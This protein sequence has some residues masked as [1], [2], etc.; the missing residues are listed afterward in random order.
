[1]TF[2]RLVPVLALACAVLFPAPQGLAQDR[3]LLVPGKQTVFQRV[4][5]RDTIDAM[6]AP[7]GAVAERLP[8]FTP[9]YVYAR[10]D[11]WT[12]VGRG[13]VGAEFYVET[14]QTVAWHQNIVAAFTLPFGRNRQLVMD[15]QEA[16]VD[17]LNHEAVRSEQQRRLDAADAGRVTPD[18]G[19][20]SVEPRQHVDIQQQFYVMPILGFVEDLHP[21]SLA[22]NLLLNVASLP[23]EGGTP[24]DSSTVF[25]AGVVFVIDTTQSM[26]PYIDRTRDIVRRVITEVEASDIGKRIHFGIIAFRDD[27]RPNPALEYRTRVILPLERRATNAPVVAA[28]DKLRAARVSSPGF[29]ED[30]F[31]G[32]RAAID[33]TDWTPN[34]A[35][36][37]GRYVIL[38]TDAGPK[39]SNSPNLLPGQE[40][41]ALT[42]R[43][44][45][46]ERGVGI[47]TFHLQTDEGEGNHTY[48]TSQY[49]PLST[50][51]SNRYLFEV[52]DG[53]PQA[54][55]QAAAA[56]LDGLLAHVRGEFAAAQDATEAER[57]VADLGLAMRLAWLG[58]TTGATAPDVISGWVSNLAVENG[59]RVAFEPRLLVNKNEL[60]TMAEIIQEFI[61][62]GE[63]IRS[64]RDAENFRA[65]IRETVL[66]MAAN[67]DRLTNARAEEPGDV[68]EFLTDL[69][70]RSRV[71]QISAQRW[72]E[73]AMERR[74]VL[75]DLRPMLRQYR[76]WLADPTVWTALYDGA[77]DGEMV[78]A[79]PFGMLP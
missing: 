54:Y 77:P 74:A 14:A 25:E 20:S 72:V 55:E 64:G 76:I 48:A 69:P 68:M 18:M 71:L 53:T 10:S 11:D 17:L 19:V 41:N 78:Y 61:E 9:L 36:Y 3:P 40:N 30:S 39:P 33:E 44:A 70:Y 23:E 12:Q 66:R 22:E 16:L 2:S 45:A 37:A 6:S 65:R 31:A 15:S 7:G 13:P 8:P 24:E 63:Q 47:L 1:M 75:D 62:Q 67:P 35:G 32:L 27:T 38:I 4:L 59:S 34:G 51:G 79:M 29:N 56:L 5:T 50:F 49:G 57:A 73:N 58:R 26:Q 52:V 60:A 46:E 21:L 42:L 43:A 28:L